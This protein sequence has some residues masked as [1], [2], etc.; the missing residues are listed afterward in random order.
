VF[1]GSTTGGEA[2]VLRADKAAKK[3]RSAVIAWN[4]KCADGQSFPGATE[5]TATTASPGF[6]PGPADLLL[7]RNRKGSF[8]GS[9]LA[10]GDLGDAAAL[11]TVR[12]TGRLR[13]KSAAGTLSAE[14]TVLD[15]ASGATRT[16]CRTG[17][18]RWRATRAPG[19][20]YG[21]KTSQDEPVVAKVDAKRRRVT[22]LL[23]SWRG[24]C[25]SGGFFRFSEALGNF[26]M[27]STGRFA[28]T[29]DEDVKL[30]DG[31]TRKFGYSL[32]G[33]LGRRSARGTL[34][35]AVAE[36]DAAGAPTEACDTGGV[37]WKATTG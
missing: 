12:V 18:L 32:A 3:L 15:K 26:P 11:I 14:A 24:A 31:G 17:S 19:R 30:E 7:S 28:D 23:V 9:Q 2:I 22:N 13:P 37:T 34:R 25:T 6:S 4:A 1:G 16:T 8:S 35:V 33:R 29:W 36:A 20:V 10:G 21:G 27:A 5:L